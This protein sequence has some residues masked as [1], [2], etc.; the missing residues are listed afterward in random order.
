MSR[1]LSQVVRTSSENARDMLNEERRRAIVGLLQRDGRVLVSSIAEHFAVSSVT[2]RNDLL[3]LHKR[4]LLQRVHGGAIAPGFAA[5]DRALREKTALHSREKA[6]IAQAAARLV[7]PR[8]TIILDSG[9]TTTEVARVLRTISPLTVITNAVNI[10]SELV[11]SPIDVVLSG[12]SLRE[13]AFS[14][15]GPIAEETLAQ[16]NAD[17]LFLGVDG[18]DA[19]HGIT[20]PNMLESKVNRVMISIA[21]EVVV[22]TDS[23]KFGR[24][25]L[26]QIAPLRAVHRIITDRGAPPS[27]LKRLRDAGI[28][29]TLV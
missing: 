3:V 21:R 28:E 23:S 4:G 26:C 18:I 29:V 2:A 22:V 20:T 19:T 16:F 6:A 8:E 12:G 10:A 14:L 24:R 1:S 15:V 13:N 11:G 5:E 27:E 17:R 9:S 25:S 7:Q